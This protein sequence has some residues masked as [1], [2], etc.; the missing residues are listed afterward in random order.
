MKSTTK[1]LHVVRMS[2][3]IGLLL[4][5]HVA[6]AYIDEPVLTPN[7]PMPNQL[8]SVTI[9]AGI[10]DGFVEWEGYPQ[11][12]RTGKNIRLVVYAQHVDFIDFCVFPSHSIM[13]PIGTFQSGAYSVQ[14][15]RFYIDDLKGPLTETLA[16]IPFQVSGLVN[17]VSLP[18]AGAPSLIF[19][20]LGLLFVAIV[21]IGRRR[22]PAAFL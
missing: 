17:S 6:F 19:L 9:S 4:S 1:L 11:V 18:S 7:A 22:S 21:G 13:I 20:G 16:T 8:V 10:C 2:G 14:V 12:T 3:F 5:A 15:D